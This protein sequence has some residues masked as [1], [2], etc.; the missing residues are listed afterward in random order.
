MVQ[1]VLVIHGGNA[2]ETHG[3][4]IDYLKTKEL[5]LEDSTYKGWKDNLAAD[6]SA[7][8]DVF[9]PRMPNA[10]NARY[11]EWKIWFEKLL[12][13]M[14]ND[15]ILIGHSLGGIFLIKY[16][17]ENKIDKK[18]SA[19][20]LVAAA[21]NT[22][23]IHPLVDFVITTNLSGLEKQGGE[24]Y[25]YHSKDDQVVPYSNCEDLA[26]AL[27]LAKVKVFTDRGHFHQP[28]FPELVQDI[29]SLT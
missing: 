8:F 14:D 16:L 5:T 3:A 4:Y 28:N 23:S 13:L 27:P 6:L 12:A 9:T 17:S 29:K 10:F 7:D 22:P 25:I 18:I 20:F 2:F 15:L 26:K 24:I 21:Y 1:Q 11:A 19:T